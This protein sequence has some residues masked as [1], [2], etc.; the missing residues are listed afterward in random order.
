MFQ[1]DLSNNVFTKIDQLGLIP[2]P[3]SDFSFF[4]FEDKFYL[5]GG[6]LNGKGYKDFYSFDVK[7]STWV[8]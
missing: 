1:V 8:A 6:E 5:F 7:S 3:R 2:S 4:A